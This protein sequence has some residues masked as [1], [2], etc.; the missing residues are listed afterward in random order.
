MYGSDGTN[1]SLHLKGLSKICPVTIRRSGP[2]IKGKAN[3]PQLARTQTG[4][5]HPRPKLLHQSINQSI[6][7]SINQSINPE[8]GQL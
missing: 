4:Q 5:R 3:A 6:S 8:E 7:Q 1:R 2:T